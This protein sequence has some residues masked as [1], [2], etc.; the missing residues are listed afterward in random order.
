MLHDLPVQE[1]LCEN[2]HG[3]VIG[4]T[5]LQLNESALYHIANEM[6]MDVNV[7][8]AVR[9]LCVLGLEW[10][11]ASWFPRSRPSLPDPPLTRALVVL[12]AA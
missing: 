4:G 10:P 5:V 7:F 2:V 1:C 11:S 6:V 12:M 3:H 8:C 9:M